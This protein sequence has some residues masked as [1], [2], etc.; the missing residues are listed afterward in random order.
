MPVSFPATP[1]MLQTP[2]YHH[3]AVAAGT[4]Q[5]HIAG[6]VG[7]DVDGAPLTP[8]DLSG[9]VG[10]AL[11]ATGRGLAAA[12]AGFS[13]VVRLTFYVVDW[14]AEQIGDLMTGIAAVADELGLPQPMPP[15]S[16]I[17]VQAL[18]EPGVL[19]EVEATAVLP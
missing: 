13:D 7:R 18:Y 17:G 4:R 1:G 16:L 6:Q 19:V 8:D 11:R 2:A 15:A 9:Q 5:V 14:Q 3:V 12:G 10:R